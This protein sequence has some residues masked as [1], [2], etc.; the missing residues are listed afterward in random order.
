MA[1]TRSSRPRADASGGAR[2]PE[3][4][5]WTGWVAFAATMMVLLGTFQAIEGFVAIFD[6]G[7][8]RVTSGGLVVSVDYTAWG[9]AHLVLGVLIVI[10]G[11]GVMA[12]NLAARTVAVLLAG[13][14]AIANLL[15]IEAYP[16]WSMIVITVDILV[17]Y[18]LTV[19]GREM[20][21]SA[22]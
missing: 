21:R 13:L 11:V 18:A 1:D 16:L 7:Y 14:S 2:G 19:H 4:T 20:K 8:Y 12:G 3:P 6:D 10:S 5:G 9:W 22:W 17:I 15:F